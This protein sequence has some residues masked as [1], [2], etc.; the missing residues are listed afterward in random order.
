[1]KV[2]LLSRYSRLGASSRLR[3]FQYLPYLESQ[4]ITVTPAPFFADK[5]LDNLY[6]G[7]RRHLKPIFRSYLQRLRYLLQS[8]YFDLLWIE[9]ELLPWLPAWGEAFLAS[10]HIPYVVEY[11]DAIFHRYDMHQNSLVRMCYR[12]K[13]RSIMR[14]AALVIVGNDYLAEYAQQAGAKQ[15]KYLPTVVDLERYCTTLKAANGVFSIGWIG[16]PV[17]AH[18]LSLVSSALVEVCRGCHSRLIVI[19]CDKFQLDGVLVETRSWSEETEVADIQSFDV[20]I[21]PLLDGPWERGKCGY[22][23]IQYMACSKPAI[24]SPVGVNQHIIED[25]INGFLAKDTDD[26]IRF[27]SVLRDNHSLRESMGRNSRMKVEKE[28]SLQVAAPR[29]ASLLYSVADN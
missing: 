28:Y 5:Y 16:T 13:V 17:T 3:S 19:G 29:L 2:L 7:R 18:Y 11:D 21:M 4:G 9:Y 14:R 6:A 10:L 24:A 26:W 12:N 27:L 15:V 23:I 1:M 20:G 22:K 25:G 8:F